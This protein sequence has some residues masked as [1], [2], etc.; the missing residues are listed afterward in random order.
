MGIRIKSIKN[1]KHHKEEHVLN[2]SFNYTFVDDAIKTIQINKKPKNKNSIIKYGTILENYSK[3]NNRCICSI[4]GIEANL[5]KIYD[6][7]TDSKIVRLYHYDKNTNVALVFN[8]DHINPLSNGGIDDITNT[9]F[10]CII[11]NSMK[12][13]IIPTEYIIKKEIETTSNS[14]INFFKN[15]YLKLFK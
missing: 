13:D 11:C 5:A 12:A 1:I 4:C 2:M 8:T 9:Q 6:T 7:P 10:V 15:L 3:N 14:F